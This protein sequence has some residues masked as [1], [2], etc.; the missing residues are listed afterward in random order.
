MSSSWKP[1][2]KPENSSTIYGLSPDGEKVLSAILNNLNSTSE[3]LL[4]AE[5]EKRVHSTPRSRSYK[6]KLINFQGKILNSNGETGKMKRD[7]SLMSIGNNF[8]SA[9]TYHDEDPS[10]PTGIK[11]SVYNSKNATFGNDTKSDGKFWPNL[12]MRNA[13]EESGWQFEENGELFAVR[14]RQL[15]G[16]KRPRTNNVT[17]ETENHKSFCQPKIL[18]Q[19]KIDEYF[20]VKKQ[21]N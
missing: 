21:K 1:A 18:R 16:R 8:S 19:V 14:N 12:F 10:C 7:F 2:S 4:A 5:E 3:Y 9:G 20:T 11:G 13:A 15:Q 6:T 17:S